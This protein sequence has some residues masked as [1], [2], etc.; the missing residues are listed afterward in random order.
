MGYQIGVS[1]AML[2][3]TGVVRKLGIVAVAEKAGLRE[4]VVKKFCANPLQSKNS[5]IAK[6]QKAV[7]A[8][9]QEQE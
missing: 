9:Q 5:D 8:L 2:D 1:D 6:I 7:A 4:S 3:T